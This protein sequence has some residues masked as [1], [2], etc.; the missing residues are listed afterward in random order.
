MPEILLGVMRFSNGVLNQFL[1]GGDLT[2]FIRSDLKG[3]FLGLV[4][5][6]LSYI[7]TK[8]TIDLRKTP[9]LK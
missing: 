4:T 9:P 6:K 1:N 7:T 2:S 8:A 3:Q 5:K